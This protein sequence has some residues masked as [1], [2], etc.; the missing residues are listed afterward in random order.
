MPPFEWER[1]FA[2]T[3]PRTWEI[4]STSQQ[5]DTGTLSLAGAVA[6]RLGWVGRPVCAERGSCELAG[7]LW[8]GSAP[9]SNGTRP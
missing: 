5:M 2:L 1:P 4:Q 6:V 8:A 9:A 7:G 3:P